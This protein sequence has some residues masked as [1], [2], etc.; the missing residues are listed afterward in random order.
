MMFNER[1][2]YVA[3]VGLKEI[4]VLMDFNENMTPKWWLYWI[5]IK[6]DRDSRECTLSNY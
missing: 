3:N 6:T 2:I 4:Q 5:Y 1:G